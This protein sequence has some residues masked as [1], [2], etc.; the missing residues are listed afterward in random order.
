MRFSKTKIVKK[1]IFTSLLFMPFQKLRLATLEF[2]KRINELHFTEPVSHV[3]NPLDYALEPHLKYLEKYAV[4]RKRILF[5]GMNPG[6]FGMAQTGVPFGEINAVRDWLK[7]SGE[8]KQPSNMH[9]KRPIQGFDCKRSEV[10]GLRLWGLFK[11]KFKTPEVF[12]SEHYVHN[13]CPLLF[14]EIGEKNEKGYCRNLTP[15]QLSLSETRYLYTLCDEYLRV[16]VDFLGVTWLIGVGAFARTRLEQVFPSGY[17]IGQILHPSPASP[18]A[19]RGFNEAAEKQM[20]D[21][22][23]W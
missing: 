10:S 11:E 9:P 18:L 17:Q 3:Y 22:G 5:L 4:G 6:P 7:I 16:L 2:S 13:Y 20:H 12:F 19:N 23:L 21:L 15:E 14:S 8:V 1:R